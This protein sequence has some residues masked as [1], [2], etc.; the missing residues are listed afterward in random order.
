MSDLKDNEYI[1]K[2]Q[3]W[4]NDAEENWPYLCGQQINRRHIASCMVN[5]YCQSIYHSLIFLDIAFG[6][7]KSCFIQ[8]KISYNPC[9]ALIFELVIDE[10]KIDK[11]NLF[12]TEK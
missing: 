6:E 11:S 3:V 1:L 2:L 12:L 4:P 7:I 8:E 10:S 9:C 5:D